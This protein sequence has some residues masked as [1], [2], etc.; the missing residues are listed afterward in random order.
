MWLRKKRDRREGGRKGRKKEVKK[1]IKKNYIYKERKGE[2]MNE[3]V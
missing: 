2:R 1:K 3:N